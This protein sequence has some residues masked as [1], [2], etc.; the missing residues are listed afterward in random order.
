MKGEKMNYNFK[1]N[2]VAFFSLFLLVIFF[3]GCV[4]AIP[5][6]VYYYATDDGY[7]ATA[8]V[9][10]NADEIWQTVT[11]V[12]DKR[13][14][15]GRIKILKK[16]DSDRLIKVTDEIQT[17]QVKV[18]SK[19]EGGSKIIIKA[20]V[21]SESKEEEAKKEEELALRIMKNLCEEAKADCK[22]EE[23]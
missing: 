16:E 5:V 1:S 3:A 19:K 6:I 9:D 8:D 2:L 10:K 17:A 13:V 21:P 22:L 4:A 12:A 11:Q 18:L 14:A 23:K 15:E 20:D 7:V